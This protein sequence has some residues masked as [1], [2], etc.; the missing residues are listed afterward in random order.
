[1]Q[2]GVTVFS[3]YFLVFSSYAQVSVDCSSRLRTIWSPETT[4][5]CPIDC[6]LPKIERASS[7][8]RDN[9]DY[10]SRSQYLV[11]LLK[12]R[13]VWTACEACL[14]LS[15]CAPR[16]APCR[17]CGSSRRALNSRNSCLAFISRQ[18]KKFRCAQHL[19]SLAFVLPFSLSV[20]WKADESWREYRG[21]FVLEF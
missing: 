12:A 17:K 2:A 6:I 5:P 9:A 4:R 7:K 8:D 18:F 3:F 10:R 16:R 20:E 11:A 15:P 19:T 14:S 1:M 13:I 21:K